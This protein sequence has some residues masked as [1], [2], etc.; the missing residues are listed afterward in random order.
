MEIRKKNTIVIYKI[1]ENWKDETTSCV[2]PL[3]LEIDQP[4][5]AS[6]RYGYIQYIKL[7]SE[8]RIEFTD[9]KISR[10]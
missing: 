2:G 5:N 9:N 7:Y 8:L 10:T 4:K 1:L 3:P 6:E